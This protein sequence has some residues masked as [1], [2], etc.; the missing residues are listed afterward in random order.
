[1]GRKS[2]LTKKWIEDFTNGIKVGNLTKYVLEAMGVTKYVLEAM[3]VSETSF[4]RWL[5]VGEDDK[6]RGKKSIYR[7]L[8]E[9]Y[10]KAKGTRI[11]S[12]VNAIRSAGDWKAKAWL[13]QRLDPK[14]YGDMSKLIVDGR[15]T[16]EVKP[17][18]DMSDEEIKEVIASIGK[19]HFPTQE[20]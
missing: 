10:K 13:L 14:V 18:E 20:E 17:L 9:S 3:G 7:E 1:M 4:Y 2:K 15:I 11:T 19:R 8:S 16:G 6:S 12:L 5:Q